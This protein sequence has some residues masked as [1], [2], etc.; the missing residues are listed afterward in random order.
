LYGVPMQLWI[1]M[2]VVDSV[3]P[4]SPKVDLTVTFL[5]VESTGHL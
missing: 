5:P 1:E 2:C 3:A 4:Q